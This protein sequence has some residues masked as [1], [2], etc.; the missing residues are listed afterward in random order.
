MNRLF[1][2]GFY[3]GL[4]QSAYFGWNYF[5]SCHAEGACDIAAIS[6][7]F[8]GWLRSHGK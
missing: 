1:R 5:P 8:E 4:V 6:I 2:I 7:M 3:F